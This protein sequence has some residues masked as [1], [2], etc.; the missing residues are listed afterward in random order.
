MGI[1]HK[2]AVS[3]HIGGIQKIEIIRSTGLGKRL[4][5]PPDP[6]FIRDVI[7]PFV[8]GGSGHQRITLTGGSSSLCSFLPLP[9]EQ[10]GTGQKPIDDIY[11]RLE[12]LPVTFTCI[13]LQVILSESQII[14]HTLVDLC[15]GRFPFGSGIIRSGL[16]IDRDTG[17]RRVF[18]IGKLVVLC[19]MQI[20]ESPKRQCLPLCLTE[21][22]RI[23]LYGKGGVAVINRLIHQIPGKRGTG[24]VGY[25]DVVE[26][27]RRVK[28]ISRT[29]NN[30]IR[31][32]V[33]LALKPTV[34]AIGK[35]INIFEK[36]VPGAVKQP[37]GIAG[38]TDFI[39]TY[40]ICRLFI[41]KI[42]ATSRQ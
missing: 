7:E 13:V 16:G 2:T 31:H 38:H 15:H 20:A 8:L 19:Q 17:S 24:I 12:F 14:K 1:G 23:A 5:M 36:I 37:F 4:R 18:Q 26:L 11:I 42:T 40:G 29:G 3:P 39:G 9:G 22:F 25:G 41:E 34:T 33:V 21:R 28:A 27:I 10:I 6:L 35:R 32:H 30:I